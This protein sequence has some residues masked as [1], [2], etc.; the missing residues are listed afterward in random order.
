[1]N[2]NIKAL[3]GYLTNY[4]SNLIIVFCSLFI[5]AVALLGVGTVFRHL[6]DNGLAGDLS[7]INNSIFLISLLIG[8]F[9]VGS[10]FRSYS[11]NLVTEK[12][13]AKI[14]SDSYKK[15]L[16]LEIAAFE[17]L[18]IGDIISRLSSDLESVGTLITNFLS[19]FI[20]NSIMLFGAVI[21]M[22]FQSPKLSLLVIFSVPVL[23]GPLLRL[24]KHVRSISKKVMVER[25][26]LSCFIEESFSAVRTLYSFNQQGHAEERF[27]EKIA[28]YLKH[29]GKRLKLRSLFFALAIIAIS[30]SITMVIWV[31]SMDIIDG[32]MTS[33][34]MV[35]FIYYA[36]IVG[37]SAGGIAEL[38]SEIQGPLAALDR[39]FD[40]QAKT[41]LPDVLDLTEGISRKFKNIPQNYDIFFENVSFSYPARPDVLAL[42][43][44]SFC[45]KQ[46]QF[47]AIVG[48]S[49]SGKSTIMQLILKFY[50]HQSGKLKIA[51]NEVN[52]YDVRDIRKIIAYTP[53]DPDIFSGT[54]RYNI[55]FSNP[56]A[57][58]EDVQEVIHLC[59]IDKFIDHLPDGIDT[60]IGEKGVR[61]SG[62]QK[63]RVAIARALLYKPEIL[64]LDEAT[65]ALDS[66]SEKEILDNIKRV[67]R[68]KMVISIAHRI[69]SVQDFDNILVIDHG[70][71]S[72]H[73]T[74]SNL[75]KTSDI[76]NS[77]YKKSI[78]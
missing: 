32:K 3:L 53:Q 54:I 24:S 2:D 49:G 64:L 30:G 73:G 65:S 13:I 75:L 15:L 76:Y 66:E 16:H 39:V 45:I 51:N 10:F 33:G 63:Q 14:R 9:A 38:F 31:G 69:S 56:C 46:N 67:M 35:S 26:E 5:V 47:T 11:I 44:I 43:N 72:D 61:M 19:F 22:F 12:I 21:L 28:T 7:S 1:M 23:L 25:S 57:K 42:E 18:K 27:N 78:T 58:E 34:Q 62:G 70:K 29:T 36:M 48:K 74:H 4:K 20:R 71:L 60:E 77:L 6:V 41:K 68:G 52:S 55:M 17:E 50:Q 8:V 37:M 40:L 59:G